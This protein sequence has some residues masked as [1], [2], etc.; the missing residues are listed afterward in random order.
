MF[1]FSARNEGTSQWFHVLMLPNPGPRA[2]DPGP[3]PRTLGPGSR[4]RPH[5]CGGPAGHAG[6]SPAGSQPV[7]HPEEAGL[8]PQHRGGDVQA[9]G[10]A[11]VTPCGEKNPHV[12]SR[13]FIQRSALSKL[14]SLKQTT[15]SGLVFT[16]DGQ[17]PQRNVVQL[18]GQTGHPVRVGSEQERF[19]VLHVRVLPHL[20]HRCFRV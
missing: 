9:E 17:V 13:I 6:P 14:C 10:H 2:L 12:N 16:G 11:V 8:R 7:R 15:S 5:L 3:G 20:H 1:L 18:F 4:T 19:S